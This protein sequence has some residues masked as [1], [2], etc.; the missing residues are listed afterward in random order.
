MRAI[1]IKERAIQ[2]PSV[3]IGDLIKNQRGLSEPATATLP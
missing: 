1:I 3:F 2:C